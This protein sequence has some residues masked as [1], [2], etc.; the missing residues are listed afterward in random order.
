MFQGVRPGSVLYILSKGEKP[1]LISAQVVSASNPY[2]S[3]KT[4]NIF[5]QNTVVDIQ[6][7]MNGETATFKEL[8]A[9][10]GFTSSPDGTIVSDNPEAMLNE[11]RNRHRTSQQVVESA[12]MHKELLAVYECMFDILDPGLAKEKE[13]E[14]RIAFLEKEVSGMKGTIT[15]IHALLLTNLKPSNEPSK[16]Q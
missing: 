8:P 15:D 5:G 1:E 11:I 3:P 6:V 4:Q 2:P 16:K 9:L 14:Q 13:K 7:K 10:D 12:P